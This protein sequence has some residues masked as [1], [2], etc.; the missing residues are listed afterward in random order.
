LCS[1]FLALIAFAIFF[2]SLSLI[3]LHDVFNIL[4]LLLGILSLVAFF[5]GIIFKL[6]EKF[7]PR[8][9]EGLI[10]GA[11]AGLAA[12]VVGGTGYYALNI[13]GCDD[14]LPT[15][16]FIR[17]LVACPSL[18]M[19]L[20]LVLGITLPNQRPAPVAH[21]VTSPEE[22]PQRVFW[23]ITSFILIGLCVNLFLSIFNNTQS[24]LFLGGNEANIV[25][26]QYLLIVGIFS[27]AF[28]YLVIWRLKW[29]LGRRE[30][31]DKQSVA[32][33]SASVTLFWGII[34][35]IV[36]WYLVGDV[37]MAFREKPIPIEARNCARLAF[38]RSTTPDVGLRVLILFVWMWILIYLGFTRRGWKA[39]FPTG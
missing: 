32:L 36:I 12:A 23:L 26:W 1:I 19:L 34:S 29:G 7:A 24:L 8:S 37:D 30:L 27:V 31:G 38:K 17:L 15:A 20:G 33:L 21:A 39:R 2:H 6:P 25:F 10:I 16:K 11:I 14:P 22:L 13:Q 5:I 18:G 28:V 3:F 9:F 35:G 4:T